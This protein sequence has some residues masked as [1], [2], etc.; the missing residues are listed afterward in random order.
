MK[1]INYAMM[2]GN[3]YARN[4]KKLDVAIFYY[5]KCLELQPND[6]MVMTN[7]ATVM[8]ENGNFQKAEIIFKK[9][10]NTHDVPN[11]Y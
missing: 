11:A 2:L 4:E 6:A 10:I 5:D 1:D 7:Y 9:A 3:I 8:M